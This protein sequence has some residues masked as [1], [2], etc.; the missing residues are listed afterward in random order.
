MSEDFS[1]IIDQ[2]KE[3]ERRVVLDFSDYLGKGMLA[4]EKIETLGN[5]SGLTPISFGINDN[6][7]NMDRENNE[8][9]RTGTN[10][11]S[12]NSFR[13]RTS[14]LLNFSDQYAQNTEILNNSSGLSPF[15]PSGQIYS[16]K[17]KSLSLFEGFSAKDGLETLGNSSGLSP[18]NFDTEPPMDAGKR[19]YSP[20]RTL[21][22]QSSGLTNFVYKEE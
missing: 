10:S 19:R 3:E 7:K 22:T 2:K 5:S 13:V 11:G 20:Q 21:R 8:L 17:K 14:S 18:L 6:N 12:V 16:I 9:K 4:K 1:L 15:R